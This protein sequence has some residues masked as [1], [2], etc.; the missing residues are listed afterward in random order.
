MHLGELRQQVSALARDAWQIASESLADVLAAVAQL[1]DAIDVVAV[2]VTQEALTRGV[3]AR[4]TSA[5]ASQW[6]ASAAPGWEIG[7]CHAVAAVAQ[8]GL[9]PDNAT[10]QRHVLSGSV[11]LRAAMTAVRQTDRVMPALPSGF[12]RSEILG[13]YVT[14]GQRATVAEQ[15]ALT[16]WLIGRYAGDT[17]EHDTTAQHRVENVTW[18]AEPTGMWA[19]TVFAPDH[20][21]TLIAAV[22]ALSAPIRR[23][24]PAT[25]LAIRDE[26][27]PA[28]RRADALIELTTAAVS[29]RPDQALGPAARVVVTID[30]DV[31]TGRLGGVGHTADG[32]LLDA[33]TV[34]RLACD[35]DLIPVVLGTPSTPLDVGRTRRLATDAI[36]TAVALRDRHCSFPLCDRPPG[37]CRV[38]HITPW[39]AGGG[40]SLAN[41]ALL[42]ERHHTIVHRD[43]LTATVHPTQGVMWH[44]DLP[45]AA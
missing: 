44:V 28:K 22:S 30:A 41:S 8:L 7:Q 43:H 5:Q 9:V 4:S 24:D 23:I 19:F 11:G 32:L 37:W 39:H 42:C 3:V 6:V 25:G 18:R 12:D 20:A 36:R 38:H 27:S 34:R 10:V 35:A 26:R 1:R 29:S 13:H 2:V 16:R 14:L 15:R 40:T 21:A 17:L 31:V 45:Q 33:G